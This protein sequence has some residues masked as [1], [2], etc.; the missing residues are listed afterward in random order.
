MNT[1]NHLSFQ[2]K[3]ML[4]VFLY[5]LALLNAPPGCR[6]SSKAFSIRATGCG[7]CQHVGEAGAAMLP[8]TRCVRQSSTLC[9]KSYLP[10]CPLLV[11]SC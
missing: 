1:I 9:P 2:R 4:Y 6:W 11:L 7:I 10:V 8:S 5:V 3:E